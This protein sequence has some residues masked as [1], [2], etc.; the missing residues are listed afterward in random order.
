M[1][2]WVKTRSIS[3]TD[4]QN[5]FG[6]VMESAVQEHVA[7][8]VTRRETPV[9]VILGVKDFGELLRGGPEGTNMR[10]VLRELSPDYELGEEV[11]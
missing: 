5:N 2:V 10:G 9:V 3:S 8:V 1:E 7:Y 4:A 6:R 11:G